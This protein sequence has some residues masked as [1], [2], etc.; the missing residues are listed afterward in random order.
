M[1]SPALYHLWKLTQIATLGCKVDVTSDA[2]QPVQK[3][4]EIQGR[5][6]FPAGIQGDALGGKGTCG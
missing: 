3:V 2:V 1:N 6:A 4:T 5:T